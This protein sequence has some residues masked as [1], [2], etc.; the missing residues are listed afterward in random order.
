VLYKEGI[1]DALHIIS[2]M[3]NELSL[4]NENV[5]NNKGIIIERAK[6]Y[7]DSINHRYNLWE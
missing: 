7:Q 1:M 6:R 2:M 4:Y 3:E 5:V